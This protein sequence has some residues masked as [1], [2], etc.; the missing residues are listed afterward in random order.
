MLRIKISTLKSCI[1]IVAFLATIQTAFAQSYTHSPNDTI[2]SNAN[3]NDVN[4]YNITQIHPTNDTLFFKI[5]K[6]S[7]SMP[8]TWEASLCTNG[9]CFT[10]LID[11]T[12][13]GPIVVG[14]NGLMS[15]HLNPHFE[16]G[17][18]IIRYTIYATNTPNQIDTLT[19][20]ITANG[21]VGINDIEKNNSIAIYPN[22]T[23]NQLTIHT[24]YE[25]GFDYLLT[26]FLGNIIIQNHSNNRNTSLHTNQM[27][28]GNYVLTIINGKNIKHSSLIIQH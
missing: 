10:T 11:S 3:Y 7:V 28:N 2:I 18:G 8:S 24:N 1:C 27:S 19:W 17:T 21:S 6:Q 23:N 20:I 26:D 25:K 14:D 13:M 12:T 22:P 5:K 15:L 16:A 9:N 4:V